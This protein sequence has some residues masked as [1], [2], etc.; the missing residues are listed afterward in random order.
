ML[1]LSVC[2]FRYE[3]ML[4]IF[5]SGKA[6]AVGVSNFNVTHL[7]EIVDSGMR[8]PAYNQ[9][10]FHLYRSRTQQATRDFCAAHNITFGGYSPLGV[11]DDQIYPSS[12]GMAWTPMA[13]DRVTTIAAK[14]SISPAQV[15]LQWQWQLGIPTQAR[16]QN[17]DHM[18]ENIALYGL[19]IMLSDD[20]MSSL[21]G[22]PQ[23]LC[24]IDGSWYECANVTQEEAD[25]MVVKVHKLGA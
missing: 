10:P 8:L 12:N 24:S 17:R 15:L 6:R 14:H 25:R 3:A 23:D 7:Q 11:P 16:S 1:T 4:E 2:L 20:E 21:N 13:D 9:C 5:D 19:G 18:A 22:A